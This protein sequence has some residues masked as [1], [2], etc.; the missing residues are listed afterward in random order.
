LLYVIFVGE[1]AG[2]H[3]LKRNYLPFSRFARP[4]AMKLEGFFIT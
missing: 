1:L 4:A 3:K 2:H